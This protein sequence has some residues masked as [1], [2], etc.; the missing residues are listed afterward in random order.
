MAYA[1]RVTVYRRNLSAQFQPRG[2]GGE[3][4]N[5]LRQAMHRACVREAPVNTRPTR[6]PGPRLRD[7][8]DSFIR[9]V[10]QYRSEASIWNSAPHAEWVH[11]GVPGRIFPDGDFLW[12]PMRKNSSSRTKRTSVRGQTANPWMD[13]AC[14]G[15]AR[16]NGAA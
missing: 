11:E 2:Q 10:N 6:E 14:Q 13:R 8:H 4:L 9:G 15:I 7:S 12:V 16:R 1:Y 3:W 5:D